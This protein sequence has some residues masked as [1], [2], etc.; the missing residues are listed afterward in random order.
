MDLPKTFRTS[1]EAAHAS[2]IKP[3]FLSRNFTLTDQRLMIWAILIVIA[4]CQIAVQLS[5]FTSL[6]PDDAELVLWAQE[7]RV[8]V[9]DHPALLSNVASILWTLG[10]DPQ[11]FIII[12]RQVLIVLT[13]WV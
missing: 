9:K 4:C 3:M 6:G 2:K 12:T 13:F 5:L 10:L 1:S 7:L 11:T 8:S